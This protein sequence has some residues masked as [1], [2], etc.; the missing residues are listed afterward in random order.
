MGCT[1]SKPVMVEGNSQQP[2]VVTFLG[3]S[4]VGKTSLLE[5]LAGELVRLITNSRRNLTRLRALS[6]FSSVKL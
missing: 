3:L 4:G 1:K 5:W 2:F 6:G